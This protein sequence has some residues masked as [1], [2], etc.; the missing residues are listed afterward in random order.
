AALAGEKPSPC[1]GHRAAPSRTNCR[2]WTVE[3]HS[4]RAAHGRASRRI[5]PGRKE[6]S[7]LMG[8][9]YLNDRAPKGDE[10]CNSFEETAPTNMRLRVAS[11]VT[12]SLGCDES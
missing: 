4:T 8:G 5:G 9:R 2:T 1:S 7:M 10:P 3:V 11:A 6:W 12:R